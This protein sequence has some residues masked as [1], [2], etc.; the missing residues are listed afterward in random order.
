MNGLSALVRD[1]AFA[2]SFRV[3]EPV[4]ATPASLL[5]LL[6]GIGGNETNLAELA[7][8]VA[9]DTLVVLPRGRLELGTGQ[10]GWFRVA[11][12]GASAPKIVPGE[13]EDSRATLV[14]FIAQLQAAHGIAAERTAIAGFSQGGILSAS[15]GLTA[16]GCVRGF[17]VAAGRILPELEPRLASREQLAHLHALVA[18]GRDDDKLPVAWAERA[19]AW[20]T[21]LGVPHATRLYPGGHGISPAMARDL[22]AWVDGL[23]APERAQATLRA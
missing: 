3:R 14:R 11:F 15:V 18:H 10:Y 7:A 20:L 19:D 5:V 13:A 8:G 4:P 9:P 21:R 17:A 6:H 2:L 1:P 12:V 22:L 16:P 23:L